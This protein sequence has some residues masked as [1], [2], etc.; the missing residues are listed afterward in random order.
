MTEQLTYKLDKITDGPDGSDLGKLSG[1]GIL[2][3]NIEVRKVKGFLEYKIV[4]FSQLLK[5]NS[6]PTVFIS[7]SCTESLTQ[8]CG[9]DHILVLLHQ[10]TLVLQALNHP[11]TV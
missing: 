4:T 11:G 6:D 2:E 9:Q 5:S 3:N 8:C 7:Y 1:L 10:A